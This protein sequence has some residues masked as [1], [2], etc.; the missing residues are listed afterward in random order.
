MARGRQSESERVGVA[1]NTGTLNLPRL[2]GR[3]RSLDELR[4][5]HLGVGVLGNAG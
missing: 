4:R 2:R 5:S 1:P 3:A